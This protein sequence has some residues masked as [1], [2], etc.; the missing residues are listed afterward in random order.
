[1][2]DKEKI[3]LL[4]R[5]ALYDKHMSDADKKINNYFLH[6]YIYAKNIRTRFF[7]CCGTIILVLFYVMYRIFVEQA[8]IFALDY[9][10]ELTGIA[11]FVAAVLVFYTLVGSLRAAVAFRAS[12][13]RIGAY[14]DVLDIT[15]GEDRLFEERV[16]NRRNGRNT[17]LPGNSNKHR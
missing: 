8:D 16:N 11:V 12:Q 10:K 2:A 14:L 5:L 7:A 9:V 1:M 6:D 13:K 17:V 3:V 15:S 4:T